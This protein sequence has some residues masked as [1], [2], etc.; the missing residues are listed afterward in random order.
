MPSLRYRYQTLQF[1]EL[2]IH[3]RSLRDISQFSD[4]EGKASDLGISSS[5][6]PLFGMIW[7]SGEALA[8]LMATY[9]VAGKRIL[10]VGCGLGLA[11][12]VLNRR[13]SD[14][15]A[16]DIHPDADS[17]MQENTRINQD[18]PVPFVRGGWSDSESELGEFDLIIGS[19][20]LYERSH[21][22]PLSDF[23]HRHA[24]INCEIVL[25]D[26]G[27]GHHA[28]FSKRMVSLGYSHRQERTST[29]DADRIIPS[30]R[31]LR[32]RR[33]V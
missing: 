11:S 17:F 8:E 12:L 33:G 25:V 4:P 14:I 28:S 6:W 9:E 31:V 27:R 19:D 22:I 3:V 30:G 24:A 15:T 32:Y 13:N 29:V 18:E 7:A 10:E 21:V 26:P 16:T 2:E 20:L 5:T 1:G 23:I